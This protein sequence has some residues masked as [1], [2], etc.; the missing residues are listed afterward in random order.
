MTPAAERRGWRLSP[1]PVAL[2]LGLV[3]FVAFMPG[4]VSS[5]SADQLAEARSGAVSD[6]HSPLLTLIWRAML[7]VV[8]NPATMLALQLALFWGG[9][10]LLAQVL[11]RSGRERQAWA[12]IAI[13]LFPHFVFFNHYILK[14]TAFY[15]AMF[16]AAA[17]CFLAQSRRG[18][19]AVALW[20]L[21]VAV[22]LVCALIRINGAF[23]VAALVLGLGLLHGRFT[24]PRLLVGALCASVV[25]ILLARTVNSRVLDAINSDGMQALQIFDLMGVQRF[26][27]DEG[28]WGE[29]ALTN[30]EVDACY[31]SFFWDSMSP[32][33]PCAALR[34]RLGAPDG[35]FFTDQ[36]R[37]QRGRLW[38]A[39]IAQ[40][41][42][43]YARHR[44]LHFNS[45]TFFAV[46]AMHARFNKAI[47]DGRNA[48]RQPLTEADVRKDYLKKSPLVWPITWLTAG[49]GLVAL[50][51]PRRQ[52][53]V[54]ARFGL[55]LLAS[56]L[57]YG[58]AYAVIGVASDVR[59]F[60]WTNLAVLLAVAIAWPDLREGW[61]RHPGR[62]AAA[63]AAV[64]GVVLV[65]LASRWFDI[66][67]V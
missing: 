5:D 9:A 66:V 50:L 29:T 56:G 57:L 26:S 23:A 58:L 3:H 60:L 13:G 40:H 21:A 55:L 44:L 34:V 22:L 7:A 52:D 20:A 47:R 8:D 33:G 11:H 12:V 51:W 31:T 35:R 38:L 46:P 17:L 27:R 65:G 25:L 16:L 53:S 62:G 1:A 32:N 15:S 63:L 41:P 67:Y 54:D 36:A 19:T 61:R 49:F 2:L 24:L 4:V 48:G 18:A 64:A 28:V 30:A 14:D 6:W 42:V 45:A 37:A 43:A 39:A 59:Y 10:A